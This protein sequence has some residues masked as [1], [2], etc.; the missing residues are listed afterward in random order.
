MNVFDPDVGQKILVSRQTYEF[1]EHPSAPGLVHCQEGRAG[2]VYQVQDPQGKRH[3]LKVFKPRFRTNRLELVTPR[4]QS[5]SKLSGCSAFWRHLITPVNNAALLD[6]YPDLEYAALM[7]WVV[8]RTWAEIV[9]ARQTLQYE[10]SIQ[11]VR[12]FLEAVA[13]LEANQTAHCDIS[14]GNVLINLENCSAHLV[15]VEDMFHRGIPAPPLIPAGSE[16][17][18]H[19]EV[20]TGYW[21]HAADRFSTA[22]LAA[23]IA[24][25]H[26]AEVRNASADIQ[27]FSQAEL[28]Q[29][30]DRYEQ[31][32]SA[33]V[34]QSVL[35]AEFLRIAW[36]SQSLTGCMRVS[37]LIEGAKTPAMSIPVTRAPKPVSHFAWFSLGF[38]VAVCIII[39]IAILLGGLII[40]ATQ[41]AN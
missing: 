34:R 19:S 24:A 15:D 41:I 40:L 22:V 14:S 30:C 9:A 16:G 28:Q 4:L 8:G 7:P 20:N 6:R 25:W 10:Q 38:S 11:L 29:A 27:Y 12:S 13:A 3:A 33:L 37:A 2:F 5:L 18:R 21:G 26:S 36:E 35:L 31:L 32:Q 1:V 23:E 39:I 17:Y